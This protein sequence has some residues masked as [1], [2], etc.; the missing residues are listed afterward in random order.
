MSQAH[1]VSQGQDPIWT[2]ISIAKFSHN[3]CPYGTRTFTWTHVGERSDLD[4]VFRSARLIDGL[5]NFAERLMM[6]VTVGAEQLEYQDLGELVK[7][8]KEYDSSSGAEHP[9]QIVIKSPFLA[10]RYPKTANTVRRIQVKFRNEADFSRALGFLRDLGLPVLDNVQPAPKFRPTPSPAPSATSSSTL[11][12]GTFQTSYIPAPAAQLFTPSFGRSLDTPAFSSTKSEF[13]IPTRPQ[14]SN[15]EVQKSFNALAFQNSSATPPLSSASSSLALDLSHCPSQAGKET[16]HLSH[17][18]LH[19]SGSD[20]ANSYFT[21]SLFNSSSKSQLGSISE[22]AEHNHRILSESPFFSYRHHPDISERELFSV[23]NLDDVFNQA[24]NPKANLVR[25]LS[26]PNDSSQIHSFSVPPPRELPFPSTQGKV[27]SASTSGLPP[28]SKPSLAETSLT[29]IAGNEDTTEKQS[30]P[31][32]KPAKKRVAQRKPSTVKKVQAIAPKEIPQVTAPATS[33]I[34]NEATNLQAPPTQIDEPSPLAARSATGSRPPSET[35]GLHS[36]ATTA[37]KRVTPPARPSSASKRSKMVDQSTQT[38]TLS[39][40]DHTILQRS[41]SPN[42]ILEHENAPIPESP[43]EDYLSSLDSFVSKYK[44][45]PKPEE[46]WQAPEYATADEA[47]RRVLLN[48]FICDNLENA[49]FL[50]L[51]QD[52]EKAWRRIGLGM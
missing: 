5:G 50:Q 18:V 46:I 8:V 31:T 34:T 16:R 28:L 33:I 3:T 21:S 13:K 24:S 39:G 19:V 43:P 49:D 20:P 2:P 36:K 9:V 14:S 11:S 7:F 15:S 29:T 42:S 30:T 1:I 38:Q 12:A 37:R 44:A 4:L 10:M 23:A 25:P 22:N 40:R 26:T 51:C 52:T 6:Q 48:D 35:S 41:I 47:K 27:R 32:R 17:P 45:R